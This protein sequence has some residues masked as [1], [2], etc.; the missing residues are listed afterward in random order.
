MQRVW[1]HLDKEDEQAVDEDTR[2]L[3]YP[4]VNKSNLANKLKTHIYT[5]CFKRA[6]AGDDSV[7]LLLCRDIHNAADHW[8]G[9]HSV[10]AQ[11]D[12]G[13]KCVQEKWGP[14]RAYYLLGGETHKAVKEWLTKKCTPAKMKFYTRAREN[15]LSE[16]FN[17]L[18]NKY[19]SKRIHY[20]KSHCARVA[21]AGLDWNEGRDREV[22]IKKQRKAAGTAVRQRGANRNI[23]SEKT[24]KWKTE[25]AKRVMPDL[26]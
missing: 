13:R 14:G 12:S 10:C 16:T 11:L 23:L 15:Y 8:G 1:A 20:S 24:T 3:K 19:A 9:D 22:L 21:C 5:S 4:E 26:F 25:V 2:L 17:S 6:E 18:I 7:A